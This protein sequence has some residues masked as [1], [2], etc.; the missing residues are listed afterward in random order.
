[1]NQNWTSETLSN[2]VAAGA[3][4]RLVHTQYADED[5]PSRLC[6]AGWMNKSTEIRLCTESCRLEDP[7]ML[8]CTRQVGMGNMKKAGGRKL[9]PR[10]VHRQKVG[11]E[12]KQCTA[13]GSFV[14]LVFLGFV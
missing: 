5:R 1:M 9:H 11:S 3:F 10:S 4:S 14:F 2:R 6:L 7:V 13:R 8:Y 12:T